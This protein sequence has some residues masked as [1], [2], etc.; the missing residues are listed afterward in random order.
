ME[1]IETQVAALKAQVQAQAAQISR[2]NA[3]LDKLRA[4][5]PWLPLKTFNLFPKLLPEL[6]NRI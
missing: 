5:L 6:R 1:P 4:R 3:E 2:L